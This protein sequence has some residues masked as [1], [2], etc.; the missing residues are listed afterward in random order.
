M[1]CR[2]K[3]RALLFAGRPHDVH[4]RGYDLRLPGVRQSAHPRAHVRNAQNLLCNLVGDDRRKT[5]SWP[6]FGSLFGA[7][8]ETRIAC[9]GQ[10]ILSLQW[11]DEAL[12]A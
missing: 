7:S 3:R 11:Q 4:A 6:M 8:T 10:A 12:T 9:L 5:L 2:Y 1:Y